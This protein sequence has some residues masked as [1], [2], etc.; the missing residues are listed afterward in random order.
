MIRKRLFLMLTF[1]LCVSFAGCEKSN[2][3]KNTEQ[4]GSEDLA[5]F[6]GED[7]TSE[8][9][10]LFAEM[11]K[12][13]GLWVEDNAGK[14]KTAD[15]VSIEK[16]ACYEFSEGKMIRK[17]DTD[18]KSSYQDECSR[19]NQQMFGNNRRWI[20]EEYVA[21]KEKN[22]E[23]RMNDGY[24]RL[25]NKDGAEIILLHE[26]NDAMYRNAEEVMF[27]KRY[28]DDEAEGTG[29]LR[30]WHYSM[31]FSTS[32]ITVTAASDKT[33]DMLAEEVLDAYREYIASRPGDVW[34]YF[35]ELTVIDVTFSDN[36]VEDSRSFT[37]TFAVNI[38][39]DYIAG[40][41]MDGTGEYEGMVIQTRV[42]YIK[43]YDGIW[44]CTG[45]SS[46]I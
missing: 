22:F 17:S 6:A 46:E 19:I 34:N 3:T 45:I 20:S 33:N 14:G 43:E 28:C 30:N 1:I 41:D 23:E 8:V 4:S 32:G 16:V 29:L 35:D 11:Y 26:S 24:Y 40:G 37:A 42:F 38:N 44:Y 21:D 18:A 9:R 7:K 36:S 10:E 5:T 31:G 2:N 13:D 27:F 15:I 12:N 25:F 39:P